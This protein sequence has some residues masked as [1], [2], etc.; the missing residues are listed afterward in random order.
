[1][2]RAGQFV[3]ANVEL[4]PPK[5]VVEVPTSAL[6]EDG[7]ES[8]VF[9]QADPGKPIYTM[10]R[11]NVTNRFADSVYIRSTPLTKT[12]ERLAGEDGRTVVKTEPLGVGERVIT[13]GALELKTALENK[14]SAAAKPDEVAK[15][16]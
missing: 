1:M 11:V 3:T 2:L 15:A 8:I 10:R 16:R 14:Q 5:N 6:V 12:E 9:V 4:L 7:K 13:A